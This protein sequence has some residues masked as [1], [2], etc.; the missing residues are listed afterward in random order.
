MKFLAT[1]KELTFS[2]IVSILAVTLVP[3]FIAY[4]VI[5]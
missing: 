3:L 4:L 5:A 1:L 2:E